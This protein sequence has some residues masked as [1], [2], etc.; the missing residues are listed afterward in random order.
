MKNPG[1]H[2]ATQDMDTVEDCPKKTAGVQSKLDDM[3]RTEHSYT[4]SEYYPRA[5]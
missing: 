1:N 2:K 3:D 5:M 4:E